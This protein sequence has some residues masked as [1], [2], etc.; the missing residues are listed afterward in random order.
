V[1]S[2]VNALQLARV[3]D[4]LLKTGSSE[5]VSRIKAE[6][7]KQFIT[8]V[9]QAPSFLAI[10][11]MQSYAPQSGQVFG[12]IKQMKED[13][14]NDLS[15]T[16][17]TEA[18]A[19]EQ[20]QLLKN[21]KSD[22]IATAKQTI[23]SIDAQLADLA[24]KNAEAAKE[25]EDTEAQVA[26]DKA[27]LVN[28][29]KKC[30]VSDAEFQARVKARQEEISAVED[31]MQILN[32]D[33]SFEAFDSS[34]NSF[35]QISSVSAEQE[36]MQRKR[37]VALLQRAADSSNSPQISL[38]ALSAQLDTFTKVKEEIDNGCRAW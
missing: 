33:E 34:V 6:A 16:Q 31:S 36:K 7:L 21:A 24:E 22:E 10:P 4:L 9:N 29:K 15:S 35:L 28:L 20:F 37:A 27:F 17:K 13:F 19:V 11:G 3:Q 14:E 2:V 26:L 32:S 30:S 18:T 8:G 5:E 25:L 38:I 23:E 1:K 12:I